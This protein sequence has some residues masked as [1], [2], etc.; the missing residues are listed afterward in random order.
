MLI[1]ILL[2]FSG[3]GFGDPSDLL[4]YVVKD[5]IK[6]NCTICG[7]TT[8]RSGDTRDHVENIHYPNIFI[9]S[10]ECGLEFKSKISLKS[11]KKTHSNQE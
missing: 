9:Y 10:C 2:N 4:A 6:Y 8:F 11:H 5:G 1:F 7:K 3:Q